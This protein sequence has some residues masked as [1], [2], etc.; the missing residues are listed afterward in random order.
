MNILLLGMLVYTKFPHR[1]LPSISPLPLL[2]TYVTSNFFK[3][4]E[5]TTKLPPFLYLLPTMLLS[6][7]SIILLTISPPTLPH[8][9]DV[10][11]PL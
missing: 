10:L 7:C 5:A 6:V 2:V 4:M 1:A 8:S 3:E 9:L 11:S